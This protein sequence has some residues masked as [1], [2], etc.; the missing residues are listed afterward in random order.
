MKYLIY[1]QQ[2]NLEDI[3]ISERSQTQKAHII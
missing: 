1:A 3:M 2:M